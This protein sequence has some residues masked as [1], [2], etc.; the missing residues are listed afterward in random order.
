MPLKNHEHVNIHTNILYIQVC[1]LIMHSIWYSAMAKPG[2]SQINF[3]SR[4]TQ[5]MLLC[6]Y[7]K[8][9]DKTSR[10]DITSVPSPDLTSPAINQASAKAESFLNLELHSIIAVQYLI[11]IIFNSAYLSA[12]RNL[13]YVSYVCN[14]CNVSKKLHIFC[15]F[16]NKIV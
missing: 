5:L 7:K 15:F 12:V 13:S 14:L 6:G 9:T 16:K 3:K 1:Y 11:I 10:C 2:Q 4:P 8:T